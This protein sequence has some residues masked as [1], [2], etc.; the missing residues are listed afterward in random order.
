MDATFVGPLFTLSGIGEEKESSV[1]VSSWKDNAGGLEVKRHFLW[2][3]SLLYPCSC[4]LSSARRRLL[5]A[6]CSVMQHFKT[7]VLAYKSFQG[8]F[9]MIPSANGDNMLIPKTTNKFLSQKWFT[10]LSREHL[11]QI[12]SMEEESVP[13]C[14]ILNNENLAQ[15]FLSCTSR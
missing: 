6:I 1:F 3:C 2:L 14:D 13:L 9:H 5:P 12:V 10:C 4:A 8:L 15:I 7:N 11:K